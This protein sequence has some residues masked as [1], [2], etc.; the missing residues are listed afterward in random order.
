MVARDEKGDLGEKQAEETTSSRLSASPAKTLQD[1]T[2]SENAISPRPS[3]HTSN[4]QSDSEYRYS[5]VDCIEW[6]A[7]AARPRNSQHTVCRINVAVMSTQ[8][9]SSAPFLCQPINGATHAAGNRETGL[10]VSHDQICCIGAIVSAF[11][12]QLVSHQEAGSAVQQT[13]LLYR[14]EHDSIIEPPPPLAML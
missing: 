13:I 7:Y 10:R 9:C 14:K 6:S 8:Y 3:Q 1:E 4:L 5:H 2:R 11:L 12:P